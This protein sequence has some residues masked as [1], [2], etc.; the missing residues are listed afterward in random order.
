MGIPTPVKAR[1]RRTGAVRTFTD[2][3]MLGRYIEELLTQQEQILNKDL[4][5]YEMVSPYYGASHRTYA[6]SPE[7][8]FQK[9]LVREEQG[10]KV[11]RSA[12][13][14]GWLA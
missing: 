12:P 8:A 1:R 9:L 6:A 2:P 7:E 11:M 10:N 4:Q 13:Y 3:N 5:E 14:R